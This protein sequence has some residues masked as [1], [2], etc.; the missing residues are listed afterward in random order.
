[1]QELDLYNPEE[2]LVVYGSLAPGGS[3]TFMFKGLEGTWHRCRIYGNM[4][5]WRGF[6]AFKWDPKGPEHDAWLFASPALPRIFPELDDFEG[7][8]Y[9]RVL[10]PARVGDHWVL[11]NI[12]EGK[13][14]E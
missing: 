9:R 12:Y 7:E 8:E 4:G 11:T 3:N 1:V 5:R 6:K 14:F 2:R 10:V 13:F